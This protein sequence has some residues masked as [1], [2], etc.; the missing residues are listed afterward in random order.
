MTVLFGATG[1]RLAEIAEGVLGDIYEQPS[2]SLDAT[3]SLLLR[4]SRVKIAGKNLLDPRIQQLQMDKEV[5]GFRR[6][7]GY[8]IAFSYPS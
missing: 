6:G 2:A 7:R 4:G 8:S 3:I 5:S 1:K